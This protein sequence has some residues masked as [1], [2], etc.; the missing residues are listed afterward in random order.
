MKVVILTD[1]YPPTIGGAGTVASQ[2]YNDLKKHN[3]VY[4]F[5]S[6]RDGMNKN[7][8]RYFWFFYYFSLKLLVNI[9]KSD[10]VIV[11]DIRSAY[12]ISSFMP[13][14]I[15][16]K[17]IYIVHG[18]EYD[19]VYQSISVKNKLILFKSK[20]NNLLKYCNK[21]VSVSSYTMN[22]F[23]NFAPDFV[24]NKISVIYAGIPSSFVISKCLPLVI[25]DKF[26][27]VSVS[28]INKRK[29]YEYMIKIFYELI[30]LNSNIEWYIYGNGPYLLELKKLVFNLNL[31]KHVFFM[32]E[33]NRD[34]IFIIEFNKYNFDLFWLMPNLPEAFGLVFIEASAR[35]IPSL[36]VN[37]Y[38]IKEAIKSGGNGEFYSTV[39]NMHNFI[40]E[41]N[42]QNI[43]KKYILESINI[44]KC[45]D[46]RIFAEKLIR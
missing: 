5:V 18:T 29:G 38:G 8:Y 41:L 10:K 11:N 24:K 19:I 34:S 9:I 23:I 42:D 27:I 12:F 3:E 35:G 1:E 28:R 46:S 31:E 17:C 16:N 40:L 21:V 22:N 2:V 6:Y 14:C 37:K 33:T 30:K 7:L 39:E 20:Y 13:K 43:K 32:D 36:T 45:F 25:N 26:R 15:M 44:A 4:L